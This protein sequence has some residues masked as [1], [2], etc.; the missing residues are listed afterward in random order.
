MVDNSNRRE[1]SAFRALGFA[2]RL[3]GFQPMHT[4]GIS[5]GEYL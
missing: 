5:A 4:G 3:V 1:G 2:A